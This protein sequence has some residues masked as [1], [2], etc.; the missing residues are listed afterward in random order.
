MSVPPDFVLNRPPSPSRKCVDVGTDKP[1][2]LCFYGGFVSRV[3]RQ[4]DGSLEPE[5][6]YDQRKDGDFPFVL[7]AGEKRPWTSNFFEFQG[8]PEERNFS[9]HI[10]DPQQ[11]IERIEVVLKPRVLDSDT[12]VV[13]MQGGGNDRIIIED[14]SIC[15]PP[16]CDVSPP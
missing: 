3:L 7:P 16:H 6:L 12:G 9:L 11:Q 1:F 10:N 2:R 14:N 5:V 4:S 13:A 15:C 8:G